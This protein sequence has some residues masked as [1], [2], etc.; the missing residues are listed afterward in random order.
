MSRDITDIEMSP[1]G[2]TTGPAV[3]APLP[4]DKKTIE[5]K[6]KDL[7][8]T[9][10]DR[11]KERGM[12]AAVV[13]ISSVLGSQFSLPSINSSPGEIVKLYFI[14]VYVFSLLSGIRDVSLSNIT[15]ASK[16]NTSGEVGTL[17]PFIRDDVLKLINA[18]KPLDVYKKIATEERVYS[19]AF[20]HKVRT[21]V[22][23]RN[24]RMIYDI[25]SDDHFPIVHL[26]YKLALLLQRDATG[27]NKEEIAFIKSCLD[28]LLSISDTINAKDTY[29][30]IG[31]FA[32]VL[33]ILINYPEFKKYVYFL[34]S[35]KVKAVV[36]AWETSG[37]LVINENRNDLN[38]LMAIFHKTSTHNR[39]EN[40]GQNIAYSLL[41][42]VLVCRE[43]LFID[44][45]QLDH[46]TWSSKFKINEAGILR[47]VR[48]Y[49]QHQ[50][51]GNLNPWEL[52]CKKKRK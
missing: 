47:C 27:I 13:G 42:D 38:E 46:D 14:F 29:L 3:N 26:P 9:T 18:F 39:K 36:G 22:T 5:I 6:R 37:R 8:Y 10:E 23:R 40:D 19:A 50:Y 31:D 33:V 45:Q 44:F 43:D 34:N 32:T 11:A 25:L 1:P 30:A 35:D 28:V 20:D 51:K 7:K 41:L 15:D 24:V 17:N 49:R 21:W 16:E 52:V 12:E 48:S 4:T 2:A